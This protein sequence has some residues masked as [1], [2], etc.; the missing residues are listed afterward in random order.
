MKKIM[1]VC[2]L[3]FLGGCT[4]MKITA[5]IPLKDGTVVN[6][7]VEVKRSIFAT[8]NFLYNPISGTIDFTA[9][10]DPGFNQNLVNL[11]NLALTAASIYG[12]A[13]TGGIAPTVQLPTATTT[14]ETTK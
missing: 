4:T 2:L 5:P 14:T 8:A 13:M 12:K 7:V 3:V 9:N 11:N 10:Q 6:A 1:M